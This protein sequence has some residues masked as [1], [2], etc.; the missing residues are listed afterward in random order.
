MQTPGEQQAEKGPSGRY[1][2]VAAPRHALG[3]SGY[4]QGKGVDMAKKKKDKK[5]KKGK[6]K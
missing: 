6:K 5:G 3:R 2:C 1:R 4:E